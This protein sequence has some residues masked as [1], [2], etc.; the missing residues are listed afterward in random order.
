M[1]MERERRCVL[2]CCGGDKSCVC[3]CR[4]VSDSVM[5]DVMVRRCGLCS[6][7]VA[8][9]PRIAFNTAKNVQ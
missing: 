4:H 9:G 5:E 7:E 8:S 6:K 3:D 1:E 2:L